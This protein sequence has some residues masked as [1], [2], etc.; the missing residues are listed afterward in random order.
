MLRARMECAA[1][2]SHLTDQSFWTFSGCGVNS[3]GETVVPSHCSPADLAGNENL[4]RS[5][6][7]ARYVGI[8]DEISKPGVSLASYGDQSCGSADH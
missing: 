2:L 5:S 6:S 8:A 4:F 1:L 7:W 3:A